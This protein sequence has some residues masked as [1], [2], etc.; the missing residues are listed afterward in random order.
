M[1]RQYKNDI[2][3]C[4]LQQQRRRQQHP[5][6]APFQSAMPVQQLHTAAAAAFF[7]KWIACMPCAKVVL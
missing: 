7:N 6:E 5:D 2:K 4:V 1:A 3:S